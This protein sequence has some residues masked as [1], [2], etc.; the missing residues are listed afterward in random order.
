MI[1]TFGYMNFVIIYKWLSKYAEGYL[2]PSIINIMI[3]L[4]LKF[5]DSVKIKLIIDFRIVKFYF[6]GIINFKSNFK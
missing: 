6:K 2:A 5:G 4:P 1:V 3:A